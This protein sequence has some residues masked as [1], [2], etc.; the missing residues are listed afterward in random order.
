[1]ALAAELNKEYRLIVDAGFILQVDDAVVPA[2]YAYQF[3][4]RPLSEYLQW[5]ELRIE[6]LNRALTGIPAE[7][8]RYHFCFGSQNSPHTTDASLHDLISL[9]LRV[10]AQM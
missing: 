4:G 1:M 7:L 2:M 9:I 5:V 6:A 3:S 8:V 10:R